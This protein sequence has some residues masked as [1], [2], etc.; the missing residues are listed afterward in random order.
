[1][2][3]VARLAREH[4][5]VALSGEGGDEIFAG[6]KTYSATMLAGWY[7][8]YV[9]GFARRIVPAIVDRL[10][11][12]HGRLSFDYMA[13]RFVRGAENP[14]MASHLAWKAIFDET[15]KASLYSD[16]GEGLEGTLRLFERAAAGVPEKDILAQLLAA[17][18]KV[19]LEGDMLVKADRMTMATSLEGRVPL[20][21]HHLVE[22]VASIPSRWKMKR[23]TKKYLL[24]KAMEPYL[25]HETLH[26][27]KQGFNVPIPSWLLGPLRERVRDTL[28]PDRIRRGG[29][30]QP[31]MVQNLIEG[32]ESR[33][34]DY[35][36]DIWTLL[37]FQTWQDSIGTSA[38][39][40]Q[41]SGPITNLVG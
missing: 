23:M 19:G 40:P 29:L 26:G 16:E 27:P 10:P 4:V 6:Y 1:V 11:V 18:T 7:R 15:R 2:L 22:L 13:K 9:P 20:L 37:M 25:P 41:E 17:D 39:N 3:S 24:R 33:Q 30:F 32:H 14:P 28:A 5:T 31:E 38:V 21:D 34:M 35:S 36:R 8:Q 12:S